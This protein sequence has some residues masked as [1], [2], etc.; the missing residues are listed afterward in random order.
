MYA[1]APVLTKC[2]SPALAPSDVA[3]VVAGAVG[4]DVSVNVLELVLVAL[5]CAV[6]VLAPPSVAAA[7][8]E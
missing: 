5:S 6:T 1:F 7:A 4:S 8:H 3:T 2:C